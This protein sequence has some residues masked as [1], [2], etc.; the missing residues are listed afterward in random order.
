MGCCTC[1]VS[2]IIY[3]ILQCLSLV[4]TVLGTA[5]GQYKLKSDTQNADGD[6]NWD[7]YVK[8]DYCVTLW[9]AK[10]KCYSGGYSKASTKDFYKGCPNR[11]K[12][13]RAAE[14][15]SIISIV[16]IALAAIFGFISLCCCSCLRVVCLILGIIT[17]GTLCV[18]W[19][20]VADSFNNKH[21]DFNIAAVV[22]A[23]SYC[24]KLQPIYNYDA[25]FALLIVGWALQ[26]INCI[27]VMLPC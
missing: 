8:D 14:V 25:G 9:G 20:M 17:V 23:N 13:F 15:L 22:D 6:M 11:Q 1:K 12:R 4:F 19:A 16:L 5:F 26:F 7:G 10:D 3:C 21:D 24:G 18:V 2:T 27:I